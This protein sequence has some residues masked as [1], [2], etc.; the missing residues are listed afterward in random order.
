[1]DRVIEA[2]T[3]PFKKFTKGDRVAHISGG[4]GVVIGNDGNDGKAIKVQFQRAVGIYDQL[5]FDLHPGWL[6][7]RGT[8][9]LA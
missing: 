1:M 6:F 9:P 3:S 7:H 2:G 5:W 8:D 4:D